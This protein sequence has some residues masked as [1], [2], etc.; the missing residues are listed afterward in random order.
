[1]EGGDN[2]GRQEG[3]NGK[4]SAAEDAAAAFAR[5]GA[6]HVLC[7]NAGVAGLKGG[8]EFISTANWEWVLGV[9]LWGVIHGHRAFLPRMI[10]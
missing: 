5:H 10:E 2:S 3:S 1:M 4:A 6:V 9:N 8:P 7:N